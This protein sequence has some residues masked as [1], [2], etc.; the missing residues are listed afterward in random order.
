MSALHDRYFEHPNGSNIKGKN[1]VLIWREIEF[2]TDI[3]HKVSFF[4]NV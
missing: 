3:L 4:Y 1:A 2:K